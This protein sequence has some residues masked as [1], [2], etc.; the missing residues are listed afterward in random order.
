LGERCESCDG[1]GAIDATAGD[2]RVHASECADA[3]D[4]GEGAV[5]RVHC[6]A[7]LRERDD[8]CVRVPCQHVAH[9]LCACSVG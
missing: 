7:E 5:E 6:V 4:V 1:V 3:S 8:W 2:P 9:G